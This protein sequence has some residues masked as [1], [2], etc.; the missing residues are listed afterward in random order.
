MRLPE[1]NYAELHNCSQPISSRKSYALNVCV[2]IMKF[3][4]FIGLCVGI[5]WLTYIIFLNCKTDDGNYRFTSISIGAAL[6]TFLSAFISLFCIFD[7]IFGKI[8]EDNINI[9]ERKYLNG[10]K[11]PRWSFLKRSSN[12]FKKGKINYYVSSAYFNIIYGE[13]ECNCE[14]ITIP[15]LA[16]DMDIVLCFQRLFKLL[17]II[18]PYKKYILSLTDKNANTRSEK[19]SAD[20]MEYYIL[21]DILVSIDKSIL[22]R[23]IIKFTI[24]LFI[25]FILSTIVFTV[26]FA[27]NIF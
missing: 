12:F 7:N 9:I 6:I 20:P 19:G 5:C 26:L 21:L 23:K 13:N 18:E 3:I 14:Q 2:A 25:V 11:L 27:C 24:C 8:Y 15:S 1:Y 17:I 22:C 10:K 16:V 4:I